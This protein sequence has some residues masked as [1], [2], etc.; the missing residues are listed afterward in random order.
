M[1]IEAAVEWITGYLNGKLGDVVPT[2]VIG[3]ILPHVMQLA[4]LDRY[5][6][7]GRAEIQASIDDALRSIGAI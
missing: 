4:E 6:A 3:L 7:R 2:V 1:G 5:D